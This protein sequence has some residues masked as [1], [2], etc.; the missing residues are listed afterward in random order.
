MTATVR[1]LPTVPPTHQ[2]AIAA[3]ADRFCV[4]CGSPADVYG[5]GGPWCSPEHRRFD[6]DS[7]TTQLRRSRASDSELLRP[8]RG[9]A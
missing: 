9:A 2:P 8:Y 3:S 4:Y 1:N 6:L 7:D 5:I